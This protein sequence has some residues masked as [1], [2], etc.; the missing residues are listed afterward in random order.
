MAL[1]GP[2][3][4]AEILSRLEILIAEAKDLD[5]SPSLRNALARNMTALRD[6]VETPQ[7]SIQ[8]RSCT[9]VSVLAAAFIDFPGIYAQS[10]Y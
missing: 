8:R 1:R 6:Q 10:I 7:A 3:S 9:D 5:D 2:L 4:K